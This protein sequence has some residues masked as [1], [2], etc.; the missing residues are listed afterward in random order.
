MVFIEVLLSY[1][2]LL[3]CF[4]AIGV[5][6]FYLVFRLMSGGM[7]FFYN[8]SS[9]FGG[10]SDALIHAERIS[11]KFNPVIKKV[12]MVPLDKT[13]LVQ[14]MVAGSKKFKRLETGYMENEILFKQ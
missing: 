13:L 7:F 12:K 11:K 2:K 1:S 4:V 8:R 9:D 3:I 6:L 10:I 14:G 5:V